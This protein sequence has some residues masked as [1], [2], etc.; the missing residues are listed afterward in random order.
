MTPKHLEREL[1]LLAHGGAEAVAL[2]MKV[3]RE[4]YAEGGHDL[5]DDWITLALPR[6]PEA[7]RVS[8]LSMLIRSVIIGE[9]KPEPPVT[10]G[11]V[12]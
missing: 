12:H 4:I 7:E 10:R 9:R 5:L 1:D 2:F 3:A 8:L 6:L 11:T